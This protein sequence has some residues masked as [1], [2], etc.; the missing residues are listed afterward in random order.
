[1]FRFAFQPVLLLAAAVF[2]AAC[3]AEEPASR[4]AVPVEADKPCA[5]DFDPVDA[6]FNGRSAAFIDV[7]RVGDQNAIEVADAVKEYVSQ[8]A[9]RLPPGVRLDTWRDRS[10]V[11]KARLNTLVRNAIQALMRS[12]TLLMM[13][14]GL[15]R[16]V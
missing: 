12:T 1:M 11:V 4:I 13:C 9:G 8:A 15:P 10:L 14:T 5:I 16:W 3:G 6:R 2:C 7:F